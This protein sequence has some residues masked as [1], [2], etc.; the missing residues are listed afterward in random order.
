MSTKHEQQVTSYEVTVVSRLVG[1]LL[2][3]CFYYINREVVTVVTYYYGKLIVLAKSL[4]LL[5]LTNLPQLTP[6]RGYRG[7]VSNPPP[8]PI[9]FLASSTINCSVLVS[10]T[11]KIKRDK[12]HSTSRGWEKEQKKQS[13]AKDRRFNKQLTKER[14]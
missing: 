2:S 14:Q 7:V 3:V 4:I 1:N 5:Q 11:Y 10:S 9:F 12:T 6:Y 8:P 13:K